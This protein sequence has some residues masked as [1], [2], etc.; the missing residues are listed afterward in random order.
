MKNESYN[1]WEDPKNKKEVGR[2]SWWDAKENKES[3]S[4]PV[5]VVKSGELW[6]AACNSETNLL[7]G[8]KL[9]GCAQ[10]KTKEEAIIK[11][12]ETI[13]IT[14]LYSEDC[15]LNYQRFIPFKSGDWKHIG[16][17][18]FSV[19]GIHVYFRYGKGMKGGRY[20]PFTKLN[21]SVSNFWT[22]YKKWKIKNSPR[23]R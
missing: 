3:Y 11:M 20:I 18:W 9:N 15:R 4:F 6:V 17:K 21:I 16:G 8:D 5:S 7:I 2:I 23:P 14:H 1:W 22:S 10:G 12:F 13:K 19:F